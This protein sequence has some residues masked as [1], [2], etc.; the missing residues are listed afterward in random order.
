MI[1]RQ[2]ASGSCRDPAMPLGEEGNAMAHRGGS[3]HG[4]NIGPEP[5]LRVLFRKA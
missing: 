4:G 3:I 5:H 2:L 1:Y